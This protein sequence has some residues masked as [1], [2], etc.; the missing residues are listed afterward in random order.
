MGRPVKRAW[1]EAAK[2][3]KING[4][5]QDVLNFSNPAWQSSNPERKRRATV[6]EA[7]DVAARR[8]ETELAG[9]PEVQAEI[10]HTLGLTYH[11]FGRYEPSEKYLRKSMQIFAEIHGADD[12][13][14]QRS[15][16]NLATTLHD[17]G[18][19]DEAIA[20]LRRALPVL[21]NDAGNDERKHM[22]AAGLSELARSLK[23]TGDLKEAEAIY[24]EGLQYARQLSGQKR[25]VLSI[26]LNNLGTLNHSRGDYGQ[27]LKYLEESLA[28]TYT[29][30]TAKQYETGIAEGNIGN[31]LK[32]F[33]RYKEAEEKL[34]KSTEIFIEAMGKDHKYVAYPLINWADV[35][36]LEGDYNAAL[37][38]AEEAYAL[39]KRI[40]PDGHIDLTRSE[41]VIGKVYTATGKLAEGEEYLR[42]ALAKRTEV[43]GPDHL[44]TA[45]TKMHLGENLIE[46]KRFAEARRSLDEALL[47]MEQKQG[48]AHP[49]TVR[50]RKIIEKLEKSE[51]AGRVEKRI[52]SAQRIKKIS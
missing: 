6:E 25:L 5:F 26:I 41:L 8:V 12:F 23:V 32:E 19:Y 42:K 49:Y 3:Q 34:K 20:I 50:C 51:H 21:R 45:T 47:A 1:A 10:F 15:A 11:G 52:S 35:K 30:S 43:L 14:V 46:Q 33:G 13:L 36:Y 28:E 37:A 48:A 22:L 17:E 38:K 44:Q 40:F 9:E 27:A 16:V 18:R 7:V 24:L 39:Q 4:F 29:Y 2:A 31:A